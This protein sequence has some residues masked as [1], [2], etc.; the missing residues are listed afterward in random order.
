[1]EMA[2]VE[3]P[4]RMLTPP[5]IAARLAVK[6]EKI[7]GWIRSGELSA[8]NVAKNVDGRPRWRVDP[9]ELDKFLIRRSATPAPKVTRRRKKKLPA[10]FVEFYGLGFLVMTFFL[11]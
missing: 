9:A 4:T 1:M 10:D 3:T 11:T 7:L 8:V 2:S 5:Q 6:P